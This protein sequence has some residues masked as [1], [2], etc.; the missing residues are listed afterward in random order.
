MFKKRR[1][2]HVPYNK[3]GLIHFTCVN[4]K[5]MPEEIQQKI[6]DLCI[7]VGGRH[8]RALYALMTDSNESVRSISGKFFISESQ[9]YIYRKQFYEKW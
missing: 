1:G 8:C 7:E 5:D 6:W 2:I 3:Q 4:V 9:L